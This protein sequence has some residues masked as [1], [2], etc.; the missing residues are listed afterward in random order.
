MTDQPVTPPSEA[1]PAKAAQYAEVAQW[2]ETY[3]Q[4][5][6]FDEEAHKGYARDREYAKG[7]SAFAVDVNLAGTFIDITES[8]LYAK[9]PDLDV[10]PSPACA[11]PDASVIEAAAAEVAKAQAERVGQQVMMQAVPQGLAA[12]LSPEQ[13]AQAGAV[14]AQQASQGAGAE[15]ALMAMDALQK[16]FQQRQR[17]AK[18][19][20][21]T[22]ELV[23]SEAWSK[24]KL[25][26]RGR[27][28]VR[29]G[30]TVALGVL[31]ASFQERQQHS[32]ATRNALQS[33]EREAQAVRHQ[34]AQLADG[35]EGRPAQEAKALEV[36]ERLKKL[37]ATP[38]ETVAR[39]FVLDV[40]R[41]ENWTIAEGFPIGEAEDAPWQAERIPMRLDLAKQTYP[42]VPKEAWGK[43]TLYQAKK[44]ERVK[45]ESP[46][47]RSHEA[48]DADG[49]VKGDA[50]GKGPTFVM[51]I[52]IWDRE[53]GVV[54][55][56]IEGL[57]CYARAPWT[58]PQTER[59]YPYFAYVVGETG[60][61]RHPVSLVTRSAKLFDE[62]NR[63]T[64]NERE[65]RARCLPKIAFNAGAIEPEE[66][67]K[68][69]AAKIGELVALKFLQPD[70]DITK[71][72]K[73][74]AYPAFDAGLYDRTRLRNELETIWGIQEALAGS[75]E[76]AKTATE[77][78]IQQQ[79][80]QSRTTGRRESLDSLLNELATY[81]AQLLREKLTKEEV[82]A[83]AGP[84]AF[85]PEYTDPQT[86]ALRLL[87]V[88]IVAGS[89]GK[90][91][92]QMDKQNWT[93]LLPIITENIDKIGTLRG[94]LPPDVA[95]A[96]AKVLKMTAERLGERFDVD[97]LLPK[98]GLPMPA[99]G[100]PG[101]DPN[102][103][104]VDPN[105]PPQPAP[106]GPPVAA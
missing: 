7:N 65:H 57:P 56:L 76:V 14:G 102:A 77:A 46:G 75:V 78:D 99:P 22:I 38:M 72:L 15:A 98:A 60:E 33:V 4:A 16:H 29:S 39:G 94:S 90:P 96:H 41:P 87:T 28:M 53:A 2:G 19:L 55:T 27:R 66:V 74:V 68:L 86:D 67:K 58:P 44:P 84:H 35:D 34:L 61:E 17:E 89:S 70:A 21:E 92:S 71:L 48:K 95:D 32:P 45:D 79:G 81:T 20:A 63:I 47:V 51:V 40:V 25:K 88:D 24:A 5:R 49:F 100:V 103:P 64:S 12:G 93:S 18:M 101:A 104:P 23:V 9:A 11:V 43:A 52:E 80:F 54:R 26:K 105:A 8:F 62:Y 91:N 42:E 37:R 6:E 10:T 31:K 82:V 83:I 59:F 69:Q 13:A 1:D 73:E 36:V 97:D 3:R 50:S 85:W 30:L 106:A